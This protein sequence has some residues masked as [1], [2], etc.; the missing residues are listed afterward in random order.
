MG[1]DEKEESVCACIKHQKM[2]QNLFCFFFSHALFPA[3]TQ[4]FL[5]PPGTM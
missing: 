5:I 4:C 3:V 2:K 1:T